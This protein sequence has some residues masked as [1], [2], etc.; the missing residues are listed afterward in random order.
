MIKKTFK[1]LKIFF[2]P[3]TIVAFA[4]MGLS[5]CQALPEK[6]QVIASESI[7]PFSFSEDQPWANPPKKIEFA[8]LLNQNNVV[9]LHLWATS[10]PSCVPELKA[11]EKFAHDYMKKDLD[12][13]TVSLNDPRSGVLRNYFSN[14]HYRHLKPYHRASRTRPAIKGLPTTFFFNRSGELVGKIEGIAPWS[15]EEMKRLVDRLLAE[16]AVKKTKPSDSYFDQALDF[17]SS[18]FS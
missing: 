17:I 6:Y 2:L 14:N 4:A 9:I 7:K 12:I 13:I 10:C 11:M 1:T 16:P 8:H 3:L 5:V 15:S 18:L